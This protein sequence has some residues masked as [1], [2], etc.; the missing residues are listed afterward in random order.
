MEGQWWTDSGRAMRGK[1]GETWILLK[2]ELVGLADGPEKEWG[3]ETGKKFCQG[4]WVKQ[5]EVKN[6]GFHSAHYKYI[7]FVIQESQNI[8]KLYWNY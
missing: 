2:L 8:L 6:W 7:S 5:L 1:N 4:Y 3:K